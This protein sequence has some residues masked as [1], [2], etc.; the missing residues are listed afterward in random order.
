MYKEIQQ[1]FHL[2]EMT[3]AFVLL[4][5]IFILIQALILKPQ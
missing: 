2:Q 4:T 1:V 3:H 5:P